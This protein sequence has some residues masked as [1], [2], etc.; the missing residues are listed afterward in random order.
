MELKSRFVRNVW[1]VSATVLMGYIVENVGFA[2][3]DTSRLVRALYLLIE[4]ARHVH[5]IVGPMAEE[6]GADRARH[7]VQV[8]ER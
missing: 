7:V 1:K 3:Q 5:F 8:S 4:C 6:G 2:V